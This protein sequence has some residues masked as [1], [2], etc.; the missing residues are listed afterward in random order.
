MLS[1][2]EVALRDAT[3]DS[4]R[5]ILEG[6]HVESWVEGSI[7]PSEMAFFLASCNVAN[8]S[9]VIESGRQD[10]YSTNILGDWASRAA[11]R[12]VVSIDLESDAKRAE[13]CRGRLARWTSLKLVKGNAY[14]E[15]GRVANAH[16]SARTAFLLDGPKQAQAI[17]I[18][19]AALNDNV[20]IVS[21]HNLVAGARDYEFFT[22][23]GGANIF[24]ESAILE[25]GPNWLELRQR[26]AAHARKVGATR[27]VD[28]SQIGVLVLNPETRAKMRG[29]VNPWFGLHQPFAVRAIWWARAYNFAPKLY[30]LS[31][32]LLGR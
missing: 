3:E 10:G 14:S 6:G 16:T 12:R 22:E 13:V 17:S 27:P 1:D 30:G 31:Y 19:A 8:V 15:F 5:L 2:Q 9:R 7:Y 26:D 20:Q 21:M 4:A 11:D 32:K 29:S 18:M 25:P 24:Y 28:L 23:L